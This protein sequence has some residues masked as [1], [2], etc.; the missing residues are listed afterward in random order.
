MLGKWYFTERGEMP[1]LVRPIEKG[2]DAAN[3][4]IDSHG[5]VACFTL[6]NDEVV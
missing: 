2:V 6:A 3:S 1:V 4:N 5:R